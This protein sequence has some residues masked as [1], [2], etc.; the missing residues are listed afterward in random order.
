M[1][2]DGA[3][4]KF[5]SSKKGV[6]VL[7]K[8]GGTLQYNSQLY[9][10]PKEHI[11]VAVI[12]AGPANPQTVADAILQTLLEEKGIAEK[13]SSDSILLQDAKV[14]DSLRDYEGFYNS[15]NGLVK[16]EISPDKTGL[17]LSTYNG[18]GF[19]PAEFL[20]YKENGRF[21]GLDGIN[22]SFADH[23]NGK[24]MIAHL[25]SSDAGIVQYEKLNNNKD[26]DASPFSGKVWVPLN[27]S[28]YDLYPKMCQT[29]TVPDIPGYILVYDGSTYIPIALKSPTE[30]WMSFNYMRDQFEV[31]LHD[32]EGET[33]LYNYGYYYSDASEL[34]AVAEGDILRTDY[35]GQNKAGKIEFGD[36]VNFSI[37]EGGR[38]VV[39]SPE[40]SVAYD[41]LTAGST[42]TYVGEGSYI[43]AVGKP[44]DA[45]KFDEY[46]MF[47][48]IENHWAK[49]YINQLVSS[50]ILAGTK[51]NQYQ[52][53]ENMT[54]LE[55]LELLQ[56]AIGIT[57]DDL[58]SWGAEPV[59][60]I[61]G[62][63]ITRGQ[64]ISVIAD[65][66]ALAGLDTNLPEEETD[67]LTKG[68]SDMQG[69][70]DVLKTKA[71]LLIKLGIFQG[72]GSRHMAP[73]DVMTRGEA[74]ATVY[75]MLKIL[76][77]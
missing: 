18:N 10:L 5:P 45:F 29:V 70:D 30:T 37:P 77:D 3:L 41:S 49:D 9:V 75:R 63:P 64:A 66:M 44:G 4:C 61:S 1:D 31:T 35:D 27:M 57:P 14:P 51:D 15:T 68:F 67:S 60:L 74:A 21:Y 72:R 36:L 58:S 25:D 8:N 11:S 42:V 17:I 2:W 59:S 33:L 40:L 26:I 71:A 55:F 19:K 6:D 73:G 48:D 24:V 50:G 69:I 47:E 12:F 20:T 23:G 56:R 76:T 13:P 34:P 43:V 53:D 38:I 46:E 62:Q 28:P 65:V 16:A 54:G 32:R 39:F 22:Y 7:S 52:P